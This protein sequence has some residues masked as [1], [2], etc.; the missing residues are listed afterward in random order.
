MKRKK[1]LLKKNRTSRQEGVGSGNNGE[2]FS[3]IIP[4]EEPGWWNGWEGEEWDFPNPLWGDGFDAYG[5]SFFLPCTD[6]EGPIDEWTT[7]TGPPDGVPDWCGLY[8]ESNGAGDTGVWC[9]FFGG[10]D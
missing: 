7:P 5:A 2:I 1:L 3:I 6:H 10:S 8:H 4:H 9:Y